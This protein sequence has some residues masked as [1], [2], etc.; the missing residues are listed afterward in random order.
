MKRKGID[1]IKGTK[2]FVELGTLVQ[3]LD[4][5]FDKASLSKNRIL[6]K[7]ENSYEPIF[8]I[9]IALERLH[10]L[11]DYQKYLMSDKDFLVHANKRIGF[12]E[13]L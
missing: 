2:V 1:L 7:F 10:G 11:L 9:K 5:I 13:L 4:S 3:K 6:R 8:G 12:T